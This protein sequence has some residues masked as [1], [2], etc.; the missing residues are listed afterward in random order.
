MA[1]GNVNGDVD[2]GHL[3][4]AARVCCCFVAWLHLHDSYPTVS[5]NMLSTGA[6]RRTRV[7]TWPQ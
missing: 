2:G 5:L 4:V 7:E 6:R 3:R 1:P